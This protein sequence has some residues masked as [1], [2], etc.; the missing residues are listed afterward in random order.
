MRKP[1]IGIVGDSIP[2][3]NV[4]G[5]K[6]RY[7]VGR[8]YVDCVLQADGVPF[9]LPIGVEARDVVDLID[10]LLIPGGD[11]L[12][13]SNFGQ[14][15]HPKSVLGN[16]GRFT[17]EKALLESLPREVP[18][19]GICYGCQVLN[20]ARGGDLIQHLPEKVG[21]DQHAS[22]QLETVRVERDT[23]TRALL[24]GDE[25]VAHSSH[26]QAIGKVGDGLR[27]S[28]WATDGTVEGIED[29]NGRWLVGLQWHPERTPDDRATQTL[30]KKF[31]EE[32]ARSREVRE[33][34]G[35]W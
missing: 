5:E 10:G 2:T 24:E 15:N 16:P 14:E 34:C 18:V 12:D 35:T 7:Y 29:L 28:A 8:Y 19:L 25:V 3:G 13:A 27:V 23:L 20:V 4:D 21:H 32:A 31:V 1:V 17:L 6:E 22:K 30:F 9:M 26:H 11:D 33:S